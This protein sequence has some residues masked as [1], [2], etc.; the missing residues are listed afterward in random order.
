MKLAHHVEQEQQGAVVDARQLAAVATEVGAAGDDLFLRFPVH[1]EG[2]VGQQII[3]ALIW[4]RVVGQGVAQHHLAIIVALD[5]EIGGGHGVGAG[6]IVLPEYFNHGLLV[7]GA[8]PVLRLGQH[9]AGATRG[10]ANGDDD[11][12]LGE[13]LGI[14][15][16]Q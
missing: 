4:K 10:V 9:P 14:G 3:K 16:Q 5:Q 15:F 2:R 8:N 7:M 13:Y 11:A 12:G 6:V 1:A